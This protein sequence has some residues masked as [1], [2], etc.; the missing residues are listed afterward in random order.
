ML[1]ADILRLIK[2]RGESLTLVK[3]TTGAYDPATSGATEST[4][5]HTIQV[6]VVG[7][8]SNLID[9][10]IIQRGDR[11]A[12]IAASGLNVTPAIGDKITG[13]GDAVRI[14]D[15]RTVRDNGQ[16]VAFVCQVRE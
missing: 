11:K 16:N 8:K 9:G 7:Y 2:D 4:A 13:L 10:S 1:A 3:T 6:A 5:N 14:I 15:K 12:I